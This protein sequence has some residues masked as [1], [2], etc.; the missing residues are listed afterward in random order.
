MAEK[1]KEQPLLQKAI[2]FA[3]MKHEGQLRKGTT[4]PY[5][6]HVM[7][8]MEIVSR[9]TDKEEI[10]AAAVLHDTL[11]DTPT[12]VEEL[13][14]FFNDNVAALVVAE[15]ENKRFGQPEE[16]TWLVRKRETIE[17]L[18][19]AKTEVKMIALGDKLS[20]V[21]AMYRDFL[22]EGDGFWKK[23]NNKDP[24][25]QGM[26]YCSVGLAF[27]EDEEIRNTQAFREYVELCAKIFHVT[28]DRDGKLVIEKT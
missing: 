3:A 6:T 28:R 23:F 21:R 14:H 7:E 22:V 19:A 5:F 15:S 2:I 13:A 9:M 1:K 26:Y 20:N 10:H 8:A 11:E 17:H 4:I 27:W 18:S 25:S 24:R 16:D 12:T